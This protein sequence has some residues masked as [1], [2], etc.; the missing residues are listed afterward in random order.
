MFQVLN[1]KNQ[2]LK[3]DVNHKDELGNSALHYATTNGNLQIFNILLKNDAI[4]DIQNNQSQTPLIIASQGG[5]PEIVQGLIQA[6]ADINFQDQFFNTPLH[7]A[8]RY[9]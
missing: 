1:F 5:Y 9:E 2:D 8:C 7:Y 6:G 4:I 3:A